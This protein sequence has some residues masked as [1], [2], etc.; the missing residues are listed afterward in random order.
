MPKVAM[1]YNPPKDENNKPWKPEDLAPHVDR[2][3]LTPKADREQFA[4]DMIKV[5]PGIEWHMYVLQHSA[6]LALPG[7]PNHN[8]AL[9][10]KGEAEAMLKQYPDIALHTTDGKPIRKNDSRDY[11][12]INTAHEQWRKRFVEHVAEVKARAPF[13][14]HLWLDDL[15]TESRFNQIGYKTVKEFPTRELYFD[16]T[17]NWLTYVRQYAALAN[18]L[19][20]GGNLQAPFNQFTD[21]QR[22]AGIMLLAGGNVLIEFAWLNHK[23][24]LDYSNWLN[25]LQKGKFVTENGGQL[26]TVL[27][28]DP[29]AIARGEKQAVADFEFALRSQMLISNGEDGMRVADKYED[30][31]NLP[32]IRGIDTQLGKPK[33]DYRVE[34]DWYRRDFENFGIAV[35]PRT[36][37]SKLVEPPIIIDPPPKPTTVKI[38]L[39][40][41]FEAPIAIAAAIQA[42]WDSHDVTMK[43]TPVP[44]TLTIE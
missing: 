32:A 12:V 39:H 6:H 28:R 37:D 3:I 14:T 11:L 9:T 40:V 23:G 24:E 31:A 15:G 38:E 1:L 30:F 20:F 27:Q 35:N 34:G 18:G 42:A 17:C 22:A 10:R 16:H 44:P 36:A 4:R 29:F 41:E 25:T 7:M 5:N 13:F 2:F 21:W 19:R 43:I 8:Q 26:N 33:G